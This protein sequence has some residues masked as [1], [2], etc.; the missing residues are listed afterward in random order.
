MI[1]TTQ[2]EEYLAFLDEVHGISNVYFHKGA[3]YVMDM[4]DLAVIEEYNDQLGYTFTAK[5]ID[6]VVIYG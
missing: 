5:L 1:N 2:Q 3:L 6:D 4:H